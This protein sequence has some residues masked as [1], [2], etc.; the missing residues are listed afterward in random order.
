MAAY[1]TI[2]DSEEEGDV[3]SG[4]EE[5]GECDD[6]EDGDSGTDW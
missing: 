4:S 5:D 2:S 6:C 3:S 1:H